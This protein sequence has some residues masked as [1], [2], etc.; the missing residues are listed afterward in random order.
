MALATPLALCADTAADLMSRDVATLETNATFAQALAFLIDNNLTVAPVTDPVGRPVGILSVAD[1]LIHVRAC[2]TMKTIAP[3]T[4]A[5]MMTPTIFT[6]REDTSAADIIRDMIR[7]KVHH[8][9][10]TD[11]AGEIVGVINACDFLKHLH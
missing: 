7:S 8:L 6:V 9:F 11:D 1:L 2:E 3:A 10:A 4:V 5:A